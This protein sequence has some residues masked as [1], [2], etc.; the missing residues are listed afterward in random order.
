MTY[1]NEMETSE[2]IIQL[3]TKSPAAFSELYDSYSAALYGVTCRMVRDRDVAKEL[4]QDAFVKIWE[5]FDKYD[6][7][8]GTLFTWMLNITSNTCK[9]YFRS[10]RYHYQTLVSGNGLD[11]VDVTYSMAHVTYQDDSRDLYQLTQNLELKYKEVI[12][13]VYIFGYSQEEVS[14]MLNIPLGTVKTR[15]RNALKILRNLY[16]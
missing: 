15:S 10:K 5:H 2:L 16:N 12:D 3:K 9:D 4:L 11:Q 13:L 7:V 14:K 6:P 1:L 8:K